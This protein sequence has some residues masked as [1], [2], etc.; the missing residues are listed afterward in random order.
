M[1]TKTP[2]RAIVHGKIDRGAYTVEK[3]YLESFPGHFVTGNLYRPKGHRSSPNRRFSGC[4]GLDSHAGWLCLQNA[5]C[6]RVD[7]GNVDFVALF[8]PK[9]LG[10]TAANDWTR[11]MATK[12]YPELQQ[13]YAM[14]GARN[15]VMLRALTHFDHNYNYVSRAAMYG[16]FNQHLNLDWDDPV[17]VEEDFQPLTRM[18][19]SVWNDQHPRPAGGVD[20]ERSLIRW[21]TKDSDR[22]ITAFTPT[23][24]KSLETY[25]E[26]VGG[27]FE[28][29]LGHTPA[30]SGA[31]VGE[32]IDRQDYDGY[33]QEHFTLVNR[34][35]RELVSSVRLDPKSRTGNGQTVL[36]IHGKGMAGLFDLD[37]SPQPEI[38]KL[39]N[40]GMSVIGADLLFQKAAHIESQGQP[41]SRQRINDNRFAGFT[42]GYNYSLFAQRVHDILSLLAYTQGGSRPAKEVYLVGVAGAGPWVSAARA[43]AGTAVSR[44]A[45]DTG[46]F[47]FAQ[48]SDW[49]DDNFLP[50]AVKYGDLPALLALGSPG[51]L[52]IAGEAGRTPVPTNN[53]VLVY[54]QGLTSFA[55]PPA[56]WLKWPISLVEEDARMGILKAML[57]FLRAMLIPKVHMA[58]ENLA[59]RQQLAVCRQSDKRPKLR[60]RDRI[61]WVWISRFWCN[62]QSALIIIQPETVIR[63]HR[64]GCKLYWR[65]KSRAGKP[66]RPRIEREIRDL[67]RRMCRENPTWGAPRILSELLLLGYD[68]AE[69]TVGKYMVRL[70]KPPSQTWRTFLDNHV[71][72]IVACDFFTLP[73]ATFRVLYV[74]IVLRHDRR[75][76]VHF[77][78]TTNPNAKWTAQ[79]IVN[80]FPF[81]E[82]PRFLIRDRDGIYGKTLQDRVHAMG[83]EEIPTGP[84]SPWQ[85]PYAERI[86]GS[87]RRECLNHLMVLGEPHLKRILI[88]YFQY[89][90]DSRP[91][92]SLNRNSPRPREVEPRCQ[93]KVVSISQVGGLHH[94]YSRAA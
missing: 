89:Y 33:T 23:N 76:V 25:H 39:L 61:F 24:P 63:W 48:L 15:N 81:D 68:V 18:E 14:F 3:V 59:L 11:E 44:T 93:G 77:N 32:V 87:I 80:A 6:L 34:A 58:I 45:I 56:T 41:A 43:L 74:F 75:Q 40:S 22:Q 29:V 57:V 82:A 35:R 17:V 94:R 85:N 4:D 51:P 1:P 78:V 67:I 9:P 54:S 10:L 55:L 64:Q 65:W 88:S 69:T 60:P 71:P 66:G 12:G 13:H 28:V 46:G 38:M 52:W 47:R 19:M 27:A 36:W 73:T 42:Y 92:L 70:R 84:R 31:V 21:M 50:G 83:I 62:W 91:N 49:R 86:I 20:H 26:I 5:C 7:A 37:G 72:Y 8:A 2:L 90:H 30:N 53:S 16:W 79:Q